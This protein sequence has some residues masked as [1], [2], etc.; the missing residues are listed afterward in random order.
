MHSRAR[1]ILYSSSDII[2]HYCKL[3]HTVEHYKLSTCL[4][5]GIEIVP[6]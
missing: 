2:H 4:P 3:N 5:V 6:P 1:A